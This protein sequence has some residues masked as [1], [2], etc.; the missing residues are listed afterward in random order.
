M[1]KERHNCLPVASSFVPA[2]LRLPVLLAA[3][4]PL[5]LGYIVGI[6]PTVWPSSSDQ[7]SSSIDAKPYM[8]QASS[9]LPVPRPI[10]RASSVSCADFQCAVLGYDA[11]EHL[12]LYTERLGGGS[13]TL[14]PV[15]TLPGSHAMSSIACN[16]GASCLA[17]GQEAGQPSSV[18]LEGG[19]LYN[20]RVPPPSESTGGGL[21]GVSCVASVW[22]LAVGFDFPTGSVAGPLA[23]VFYGRRWA[24][25]S[26]APRNSAVSLDAASCTTVRRAIRCAAVGY[27][28]GG[29]LSSFPPS[30]ARP[31]PFIS[32]YGGG[33]WNTIALTP[34]YGRLFGVSCWP[35]DCVAVGRGDTSSGS[36]AL[37]IQQTV[38]GWRTST[39]AMKGG[40]TAVSCWSPGN[41][42][43]GS[44]AGD[45][46]VM[47][48]QRYHVVR[49][50]SGSFTGV[51]CVARGATG[52]CM[53][54]GSRRA[55]NSA[56]LVPLVVS[57]LF[58]H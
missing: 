52:I 14:S 24:I 22:C 57:A 29:E 39:P 51:S 4:V 40:L 6:A 55:A 49:T 42:A 46:I 58:R 2:R 9:S 12:E 31:V 20:L 21:D 15:L 35:R 32:S 8:L 3:Q 13:W 17:V 27:K 26:V 43:I 47:Q 18:N 28:L 41:C 44:S 19:R 7:T 50:M 45:M 54:V 5:L 23:Y 33:R 34:G 37:V 30:S 25:S 11:K 38:N 1:T 16:A 56:G 36:S 48:D 53:F 10:V